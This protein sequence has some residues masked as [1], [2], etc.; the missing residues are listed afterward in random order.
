MHYYKIYTTRL[1]QHLCRNGFFCVEST[2]NVDK[3]WLNVFLFEDTPELREAV[4][5]YQEAYHKAPEGEESAR[6]AHD[7]K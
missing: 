6:E 5:R 4:S 7:G 3:P 1:A 2:P